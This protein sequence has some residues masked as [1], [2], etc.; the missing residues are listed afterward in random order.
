MTV[1]CS[2]ADRLPFLFRVEQ[3]TLDMTQNM[4]ALP[5]CL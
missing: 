5:L 3:K 2:F 4:R 1:Q